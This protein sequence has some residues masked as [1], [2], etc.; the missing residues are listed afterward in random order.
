MAPY[1]VDL[2]RHLRSRVT[3]KYAMRLHMYVIALSTLQRLELWLHLAKSSRLLF[4]A[5]VVCKV[6]CTL[7]LATRSDTPRM[8][9]S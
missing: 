1:V 4:A 9:K 5:A 2:W 6:V 7:H 8:W 3:T